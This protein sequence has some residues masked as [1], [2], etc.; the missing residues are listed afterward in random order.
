MYVVIL[1]TSA[2]KKEAGAIA[3]ALIKKKLAACVNITKAAESLF[4]WKGK[5]DAAKELLLIIKS[6]RALLPRIIKTIKSKHSYDVP[7]VI[8]LPII[9][10]NPDYLRWIDDSLRKPR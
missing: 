6:K 1:V 2:S 8:A 7:E 5:V 10:G 9:S 3:Q 4:W